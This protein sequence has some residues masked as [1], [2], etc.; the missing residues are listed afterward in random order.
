MIE[1]ASDQDLRACVSFFGALFFRGAG[2]LQSLGHIHQPGE[3]WP[4]RHSGTQA[5]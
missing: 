3:K 2:R 1:T 5:R 4:F